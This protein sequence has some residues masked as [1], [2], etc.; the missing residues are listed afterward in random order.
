[1]YFQ[2]I[3][4]IKARLKNV[5]LTLH[6]GSGIKNS[7][8][9]KARKFGIFKIN[10]NTELREVFKNTL[11]RSLLSD[12]LRPYSFLQAPIKE[13]SKIVEKKFKII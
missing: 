11:K 8:I 12:S 7:E 10:I 13:L 2:R 3:K 9:K 4:E 5:F 6:G 1:L